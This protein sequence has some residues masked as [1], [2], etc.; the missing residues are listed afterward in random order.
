MVRITEGVT[1]QANINLQ[2][3]ARMLREMQ[4]NSGESAKECDMFWHKKKYPVRVC[5]WLSQVKRRKWVTTRDL[6]TRTP[7]GDVSIIAGMETDLFSKVPDTDHPSFWLASVV[8]DYMRTS[9]DWTRKEADIAFSFLMHQAAI[10]IRARME[11]D[12]GKREANKECIKLMRVA[13][14]YLIGVSGVI[15]SVYI[16]VGKLKDKLLRR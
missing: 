16:G 7:V 9:K 4:A 15:G 1:A 12:H 13:S 3:H 2:L 10:T 6:T 5:D 11:E 8:H 14:L